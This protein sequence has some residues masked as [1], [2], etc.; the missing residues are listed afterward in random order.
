M[1]VLLNKIA[2]VTGATSGIGRATALTLAREGCQVILAGRRAERLQAVGQQISQQHKRDWLALELDVRDEQAVNQSIEGLPAH[3][4]QIDILVNN[5]GLAA[6]FEKLYEGNSEDWNR[7]LD[8]NV[9]GLLYLTRAVVPGMVDRGSGDIVNIGSIAGHEAYPN[10]AVYCATKH[11]VDAITRSLRMDLVD[12][13]LRV[14]TVDPGLVETEFSVVR[15][16]GD[17]QKAKS[18]YQGM[19]PLT[20]EDIAELVAF[21]VA[22][23]AHVQIA[24]M[25]VFPTDQA[26]ATMVHRKSK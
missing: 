20:G 1:S 5:A 14:S 22:R 7:M 18:V 10:G 24:E 2:L 11:A 6:G 12:T 9:K 16:H 8:T 17:E 19:R 21:I 3:W 23:P 13:P 15:F 4:K 26:A 25:I